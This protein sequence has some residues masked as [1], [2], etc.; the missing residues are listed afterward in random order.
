MYLN[1]LEFLDEEREAWR[2]FEALPSLSDEDLARPCGVAHGWSG[3]DLMGHLLAWLENALA[4]A[5]EL[6]VGEES[7]TIARSDAEWDSR[8]GEVVNAELLERYRA[9]PLDDLRARYA[10]VPG[11]LR[12]TLTV[13]PEARWVKHPDH[14]RWLMDETI[15]HYADHD[16]D[17]RAILA[18]AGS[19]G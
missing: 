17:L 11:E 10:S 1:A 13:V 8:G 15:D 18:Q 2:P 7:A 16:V 3:R 19:V 14:M 12:G 9:L 5:R 6:A 4:A